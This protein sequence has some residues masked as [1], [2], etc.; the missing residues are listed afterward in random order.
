MIAGLLVMPIQDDKAQV[1]F[2]RTLAR[3][4][5]KQETR[6]PKAVKRKKVSLVAYKAYGLSFLN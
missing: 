6:Q 2:V 4:C 1:R 5:H 3:L